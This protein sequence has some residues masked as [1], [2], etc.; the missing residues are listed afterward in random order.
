MLPP[1]HE[2]S[3]FHDPTG[4]R[5]RAIRRATLIAGVLSTLVAL[6]V[7]V[8]FVIPQTLPQ[9]TDASKKIGAAPSAAAR[10]ADP[11]LAARQHAAHQRLMAALA[12][13]PAPTAT[14][15]ESLRVEK[16]R[17]SEKPVARAA[18]ANVDRPKIVAGFFVNWNDNSLESLRAHARD[19]DWVI[20]EWAF[21]QSTSDSLKLSPKPQALEI[22]ERLP[23]KE[24]PRIFAMASNYDNG[25]GRFDS[26]AVMKL[27]ATPASR[28]RA[29]IQLVNFAQ[30][31]GLAG[32]VVDFE[33][34][35]YRMNDE[36]FTFMRLLR[37]G[38]APGGRLLA[39]TM[40][41]SA[42]EEQARKYASNCDYVFLM[43]YD[44]HYG[45]G[46]PGPVASQ[47][48][49]EAK[50]RQFAQWIPSKQT[51]LALGAYGYHWDD[52]GGKL[53]GRELTFQDA[54]QLSREHGAIIQ[55]DSVSLNP[56]LHWTDPD[57]TDHLVWFL[58]GVTAFNQARFG[59]HL[60]VAG[61]AVWRLGNEDPS[62]WNAISND[63][64]SA[65]PSS[66]EAMGPGYDVPFLGRGD[67]LRIVA[68]PTPGHRLVTSDPITGR[69]TSETI[70]ETPTPWLVQRFGASDSMKIALSFDDGPDPRYTPFILDTLRS[71]G[72]KA[73][74]FVLGKQANEYPALLRRI[75]REGHEIGNHTYTHP[76]LAETTPLVARLE[77]VATGRLIESI[78]GRRTALFRPPFFG[79]SDPTTANELVPIGIATDLGYV[80]T[81]VTLDSKD[82][83]LTNPDSILA[84]TLDL[85]GS[86]NVV[87]LHD[88]GGD[89]SGTVAMLGA[90]ID[91][92][93]A[94]D[95]PLVLVSELAGISRDT[96]MPQLES[97]TFLARIG[98]IMGFG[99]LWLF[100]WLLT[101]TFLVAMALALARL[102]F[103]IC[104]AALQ[105][106]FHRAPARGSFTPP[107]AIIVPAY[108]EERVIVRTIESLLA[109]DY[110]GSFEIV[111]VDDGSPDRTFD[112]ARDA[113][114]LESRVRVMRKENGGKSSALNVGIAH[115]HADIVVCLDAD[116][117]F[118]PHTVSALVAPLVDPKMGAVAGNAKVGNRV[119][120]VTRW[121]AL[122]YITSQNLDRR[123]FA[124]LDC[125]T[126]IPG[127]VG[128]WRRSAV[129]EA[130]GFT[131]DTLAEDQDLT[132][133]IRRLGHTIGYA[134]D[135][136]AWT[137]APDTLSALAKQRFRWSFGTL[138]CAW[139]HRDAL[140]RSR[141]G[142]LGW[143]ALPNT[144]LFQLL[145][146]A[147]SPLADLVFVWSLLNVWLTWRVH[148]EHYA[149]T[150]L[151]QLMLYYGVFVIVDWLAA[152]IAF[153]MEPDEEAG[154]SWLIMLQRFVYRQLMYS[155]VWR[156]I[157]AA[158]RGGVV[159]W[160]KL[161][162]KATVTRPATG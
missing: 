15:P 141:Y 103:I 44:E 32:V 123:A 151:R 56:R 152:L 118:E 69:V 102:V 26:T 4:K 64:P 98:G 112:V 29:A 127:A 31:Y 45:L 78:T 158:V 99:A 82:W 7:A 19:L 5:W 8:L 122:E 67:L 146:A 162:R 17:I 66:L 161:D 145:L 34:V 14:R 79:D 75:V 27:L 113:F 41:V 115:T 43:L 1:S 128:A 73:T 91:S 2:P 50:T 30:K 25:L 77:I 47:R 40:A 142:A 111:I 154:L 139:K 129:V 21:T 84:N 68:R 63:V 6:G 93:K 135:A 108:N 10:L 150:D 3:V 55:L 133:R 138:Q 60:G 35:P 156:S 20:A 149:L 144:W 18:N 100:N 132:I 137:E 87:L 23:E 59:Q 37:A 12:Q 36:L 107:I 38:L 28:E 54:I 72:V 83:R 125:I 121:Q 58:D 89:R 71:R 117:E 116:T 48:W 95:H 148:G 96:A 74:F 57:G 97:T 90:L 24:R 65:S 42:D 114:A 131:N 76:N 140:L 136:I 134:E 49:F 105:R 92:L 147:L 126:V 124:L 160:G 16:N 88:S 80:T 85:L 101:W 11:K 51:I 155:V 81:G 153:V 130:G 143:V 106:R 53:N 104:I 119:N 52:A 33:E 157:I 70:T 61:A 120:L 62:L 159:G 109:Q 94:N 39:A 22:V 13:N 110:T 9:L 86:G 46:D